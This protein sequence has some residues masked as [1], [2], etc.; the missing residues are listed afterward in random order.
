MNT[1]P[2]R[3]S[4]TLFLLVPLVLMSS[5]ATAQETLESGFTSL[6]NGKNL[7]GWNILPTTE[8]QKRQH[9]RWK[10]SSPDAPPWPIYEEKIDLEGKTQTPDG[11]FVAAD[12]ILK[13][14]VPEEGRKIQFIF[15]KREFKDDFVLKLQFR[16]APKADSG[17]FIRGKQLQCRDYPNAG[18]YKELSNFKAG[19]WNDLTVTV[20]GQTAH[21]MCNDEVIEAEFKVPESG[22]IGIEGDL[23]QIEYRNIRIGPTNDGLLKATNKVDS[24][25]FETSGNGKGTIK[26]D[27]DAITFSTTV[28]GDENW[29]V[30]AYQANVDLE[31]G[32]TYSLSFEIKSPDSVTVLLMGIINEEDWHEIGLHEEVSTE[33]EYRK[34]SFAFIATDTVKGNNRIGFALGD[35]EGDVSVRNMQLIKK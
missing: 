6:F 12:G 24:W 7:D 21:C 32:A 2:I 18:P 1:F 15:T 29:H 35:Y 31:E 26:E 34:K 14:T 5:I 22:P 19:D 16:A 9:A 20:R 23:G 3:S 27:G 11:R 4:V 33:D 13:A 8:K 28:T 25:T 10:K 17:V 30:Q